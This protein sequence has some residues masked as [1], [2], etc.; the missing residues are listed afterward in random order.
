MKKLLVIAP[1]P[2]DETLGVGGTIKRFSEMGW[3]VSVV[4]VA[5]HMPP[6]YSKEVF[7]TTI[8]ESKAAHQVLGVTE[9]VY[10][11]KPAVL[12]GDIPLHEFNA[13]ISEQVDRV[14][15]D[16]LLVPFYD[17]HVDHRMIFD[18][19]MVAARPVNRGRNIKL[20]AAYETISETHWNAPHIEPGFVPNFCID[21]TNQID[22]K[23]EAM[24]C[25]QS[26]LHEFPG[27][28]SIESLS[29]LALFRGSQAGYG[30]AEAFH[31]IRMGAELF[32]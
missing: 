11:D 1:H 14:S 17:R 8:R 3:N 20:V 2:D 7:E 29:A 22:A 32:L 13:L 24:R 21:I 16:V 6:L 26:Q 31:V 28:R 15:P 5:A 23:L 19:C 9:S 27:A 18:A 10:L 30:Y 12:L 4:T 25:F